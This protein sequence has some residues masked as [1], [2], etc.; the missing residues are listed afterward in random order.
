MKP[1]EISLSQEP[2]N[3]E[4]LLGDRIDNLYPERTN[5]G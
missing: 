2:S 5:P 4:Y 1:E 3:D